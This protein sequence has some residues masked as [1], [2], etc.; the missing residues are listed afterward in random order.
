MV[1]ACYSIFFPHE[2][3]LFQLTSRY[4]LVS[5]PVWSQFIHASSQS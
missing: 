1:S 4:R 2:T 5:K 3:T